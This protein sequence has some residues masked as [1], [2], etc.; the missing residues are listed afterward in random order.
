M[1][2][3]LMN[4]R[5][6]AMASVRP[7]GCVFQGDLWRGGAAEPEPRSLVVIDQAGWIAAAGPATELPIP[8]DLPSYGGEGCWVGPGLVD[9]HVHLAFG[10]LEEMLAGGVVAVRDLGAPLEA[11]LRWS[12]SPGGPAVA[13]AGPIL[14]ASGGYPMNSW[15]ADGF[16]I[17]VTSPAQARGI[18]TDLSRVGVGVIKIALEP[19]AGQPVPSAEITRAVVDAAHEAGLAVIAHALTVEMVERAV[20]AGVDELAHTPVERLPEPLIDKLAAGGT[21][22]VSTLH[23][24]AAYPASAVRE[25]ADALVGAGVPLAY[26]TDLGNE[27][28]RTG[29]EPRELE[30]LARAGLD[31]RGAVVAATGRA[32]G[33]AGLRR[34]TGLG[35]ISV[36][37][38]A[39]CVALPTD[40]FL[41][42]QAWRT[43]IASVAGGTV[44]SM[45]GTDNPG[46]SPVAE[47]PRSGAPAGVQSAAAAPTRLGLGPAEHGP[48][49]RTSGA[50]SRRP[51]QEPHL[52]AAASMGMQQAGDPQREGG[53]PAAPW[54]SGPPAEGAA[55]A[56]GMLAGYRRDLSAAMIVLLA[57]LPLGALM[58]LVWERVAPKAHWMV[59]GG[60]AV[61]SEVEQSDFVAAD[62]W[63]AVL[64]AVAGL[65]CGTIA[66]VLF[67]GRTRTLPIGLA[68][69]GI[70]GSLVAWR[71]G[72]ALGPGP[73][74]SHRGA[75]DGSTF[76]GPLDLRAEGVL[77][78]WPIAALLAV[79]VL[80]VIFD[81]E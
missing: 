81:R 4:Q 66:F 77:L 30:L 1:G 51:G 34:L 64:G 29:A 46:V 27:G 59:Q 35:S 48:I 39:Y 36:G 58:G 18:V 41:D 68:A 37:S 72:Q 52:P 10:R 53:L 60:G 45:H 9:A 71:L 43:P 57:S 22:V 78:S 16:G 50:E 11:A 74:G 15:G 7:R 69:G 13:V 24:F 23:A 8:A 73:I 12:A 76:D 31:I 70:L 5:L 26:G 33:V 25:N 20:A 38:P 40:P 44:W 28:T 17:S 63:F 19:V 3:R 79:L 55:S 32:A 21:T 65:L 67:R 62:G 2:R 47:E 42:L 61:L 75:P 14:T 6:K 80:T 54:A 49:E 56:R